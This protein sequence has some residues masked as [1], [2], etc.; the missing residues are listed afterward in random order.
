MSA[1]ATHCTDPDRLAILTPM[2]IALLSYE[3]PPLTGFGGIGTYTW[4]QARA[5]AKLG[6]QVHVLA[7]ATEYAPL[8]PDLSHGVTVWRTNGL[9]FGARAIG[10]LHGLGLPWTRSRIENAIH[11][12]HALQ[13]LDRRIGFDVVEGP[14]CG[15][16]TLFATAV[17]DAPVVVRFQSPAE[18]IMPFYDASALDTYA[19]S[20]IEHVGIRRAHRLISS[21]AFVAAEVKGKL[22]VMH[23]IEVI[24]NGIDLDWFD[25]RPR[26]DLTP[27]FNLPTDRISIFFGAR[28]ERRKGVHLF[29]DIL[30]GVLA[31]H[32]V[33]IILAGRDDT[34]YVQNS[35]VPEIRE[36]AR[37][38]RI[39]YLGALSLDEVRA[40]LRQSDIFLFPS[41]WDSCPSACLEAMA[42]SRAVVA[43][44]AGGIPELIEHGVNGLIAPAG[45]ATAFVDALSECVESAALRET[46]GAAARRTVEQRF[47]DT[48][49][50]ERSLDVYRSMQR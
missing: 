38:G 31:R 48:I 40:C 3:Y 19:C 41:L 20:M 45:N 33:S 23:P 4:H 29:R 21:S 17:T 32:D 18:L 27:A 30:L 42:A 26:F 8:T 9:G 36:R 1:P 39:N 14:E 13:D 44:D 50:A 12:R 49:V 2:R 7:G 28:M 47:T 5:L 22:G 11:A 34:G 15:A 25:S 46:L 35:L 10:R 16:D 43:S 37:H 24:P 6:H